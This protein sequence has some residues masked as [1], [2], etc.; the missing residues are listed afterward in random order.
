MARNDSH[1]ASR[2]GGAEC[3]SRTSSGGNELAMESGW[4]HPTFTTAGRAKLV[5][6]VALAIHNVATCSIRW[7][8]SYDGARRRPN[9][10]LLRDEIRL[11]RSPS[12]VIATTIRILVLEFRPTEHRTDN[13]AHDT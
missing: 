3:S 9:N 11:E 5:V 12:G 6:G 8:I 2:S 4:L 1:A 13:D 10:E 7:P